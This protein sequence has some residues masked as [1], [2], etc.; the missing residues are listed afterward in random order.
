MPTTASMYGFWGHAN[1][2]T[3]TKQMVMDN[4]NIAVNLSSASSKGRGA[5]SVRPSKALS[6]SG[7]YPVSNGVDWFGNGDIGCYKNTSGK[8]ANYNATNTLMFFGDSIHEG[9]AQIDWWNT[10]ATNGITAIKNGT[11]NPGAIGG[12]GYQTMM[13]LIDWNALNYFPEWG[14]LCVGVNNLDLSGVRTPT[15]LTNQRLAEQLV[16][17]MEKLQYWGIKPIWL[18]IPSLKGNSGGV[19]DPQA[20]NA[21]VEPL[22]KANGWIYGNVINYMIAKNASW[23]TVYYDAYATDVHPNTTG[24][25]VMAE[26]ALQLVNE[27]RT[28]GA[29]YGAVR[30][31]IISKGFSKHFG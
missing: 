28:A 1:D 25:Q 31:P 14:V 30:R 7:G 8:K 15:D 9:T 11:D 5:L 24:R 26:Y 2:G 13:T 27:A 4:S 12:K 19:T 17:L 29:T 22:C 6:L 3:Y 23:Q 10:N 18:G 16:E 20:V 21:I